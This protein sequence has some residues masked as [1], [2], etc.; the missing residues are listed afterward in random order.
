VVSHDG[1][2]VQLNLLD[3]PG[4]A[5]LGENDAF[6]DV[7]GR[8]YPRATPGR[9]DELVSDPDTG[10]LLVRATAASAGGELVVW[11]PTADGPAHRVVVEG[12][13]DVQEHAVA[14][15]RI[16]T[17]RVAAPGAYQLVVGPAGAPPV[18][19]PA[20][21]APPADPVTAPPAFTG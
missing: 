20:P 13:V 2:E 8:G 4:N 16:V 7:L 3:C 15:G 17:A 10:Q 11:T 21:P 5:D 19:P 9:I 18:A 1:T 6:L 14:G 12:L